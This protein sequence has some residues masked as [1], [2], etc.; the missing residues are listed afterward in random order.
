[1]CRPSWPAGM[2]CAWGRGG[3]SCWCWTR[4]PCGSRCRLHAF[5]G[6]VRSLLAV[7]PGIV[8]KPLSRLFSKKDSLSSASGG[9]SST[10]PA[11]CGMAQQQQSSS[12]QGSCFLA[13]RRSRSLASNNTLTAPIYECG[14]GSSGPADD[15]TVLFSF[16]TGY[17]GR[18]WGLLKLP[19]RVPSPLGAPRQ[20]RRREEEG[21]RGRRGGQRRCPQASREAQSGHQLPHPVVV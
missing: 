18:G 4:P 6:A 5:S 16:G 12:E 1:M 21:R 8:G 20:Q 7:S 19:A 14:G 13:N 2:S 17:R 10:I 9:S 3:G 15:R 11:T